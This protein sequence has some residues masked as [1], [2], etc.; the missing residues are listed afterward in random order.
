M[1]LSRHVVKLLWCAVALALLLPGVPVSHA[2][3]PA[4][5]R[6]RAPARGL[7][8]MGGG[9]VEGLEGLASLFSGLGDLGEGGA[10]ADGSV[11]TEKRRRGGC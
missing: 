5:A 11:G 2:K 9:G 1:E 4:Q 10:T 8:G 3:G 6:R 7:G